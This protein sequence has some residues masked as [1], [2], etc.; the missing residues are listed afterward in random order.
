MS[1]PVGLSKK[2]VQNLGKYRLLLLFLKNPS[3]PYPSPLFPS[4]PNKQ[5]RNNFDRQWVSGGGV[6]KFIF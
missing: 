4:P 6:A 3:T 1:V 5:M 2:N